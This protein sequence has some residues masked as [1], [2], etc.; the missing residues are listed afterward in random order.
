MNMKDIKMVLF[1]VDNTLVYGPGAKK[2]YR[3]Y[4]G[5]IEKSFAEAF[6][7]ELLEGTRIVSAHRSRYG[8]M[9]EKA[10]ETYHLGMDLCYD[11][12]M[13]LDPEEYLELLPMVNKIIGSLKEKEVVVG[14]V[15]DGPRGLMDGIFAATGI[16]ASLF[17]FVIGWERGAAMPK[18]GSGSIY[19]RI[20]GERGIAKERAV[21]V[22]DSLYTDILP[23]VGVG[24]KA[25]HISEEK[26]AATGDFITLKNIELLPDIKIV[27]AIVS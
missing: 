13:K 12:L 27:R 4:A 19:E 9:G 18:Y 5:I 3:Q 22:G 23:A 26:E 11:A 15:S 6:G 1:D 21:M 16:E 2:F 8:G 7:R 10:F 20:C 14:V 25:I 24:L 17:D